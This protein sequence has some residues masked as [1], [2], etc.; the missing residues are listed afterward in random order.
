MGWIN[1]KHVET[2]ERERERLHLDHSH[3][4]V[5]EPGAGSLSKVMRQVMLPCV[6]GGMFW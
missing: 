3:E 4:L 1:K 2:R 5:C 6:I